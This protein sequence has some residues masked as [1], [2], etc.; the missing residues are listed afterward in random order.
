MAVLKLGPVSARCVALASFVAAALLSGCATGED[1]TT[2]S[3]LDAKGYTLSST[4]QNWH[5]DSL[6]NAIHARTTAIAAL[7]Q[8]S[9]S[10]AEA[11]APTLSV[12]FAR[13]TGTASDAD[14]ALS[15]I[16]FE[17]SAVD[18]Y[19][20]ALKAKGCPTVNID[21]KIATAAGNPPPAPLP[22]IEKVSKQDH[23]FGG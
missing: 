11:P 10:N 3:L 1:V 6:E 18:A 21:A 23:R 5:C 16:R 12:A 22:V 2:G 17:R 20:A 8:K 9:K 4:E 19:N 14:P 7:S 13:M 15:Q